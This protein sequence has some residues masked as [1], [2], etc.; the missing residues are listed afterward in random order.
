MV[1]SL[2]D[3]EDF[4]ELFFKQI[5]VNLENCEDRAAM[6]FNELYSSWRLLTIPSSATVKEKLT[7][8]IGAAKTNTLRKVLE[9]KLNTRELPES[10]EI[11]LYYEIK[12]RKPLGL[13][14]AIRS[15]AH[16]RMGECDW[17]NE[18]ELIRSV[19]QQYQKTL[20]DFPA[21]K[22]IAKEDFSYATK[23]A[24]IKA[25]FQKRRE[26]IEKQELESEEYRLAMDALLDERKNALAT[27]AIDWLDEHLED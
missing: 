6:A 19:E 16:G 21:F 13:D 26:K 11:Y 4:K 23:K 10:V 14:T 20:I 25:G 3:H 1:A 15:M 17:V 2:E 7:L 12:L 24:K 5:Q 22:K 27:L 18:I 9:K 8:L